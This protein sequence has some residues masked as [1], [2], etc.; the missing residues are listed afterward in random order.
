MVVN[1]RNFN[2]RITTNG[3][4]ASIALLGVLGCGSNQN[5]SSPA[6]AKSSSKQLT[7]NV[8]Y[9]DV[10]MNNAIHKARSTVPVFISALKNPR[11]GMMQFQIKMRLIDP[12]QANDEHIWLS[13]VTYDGSQFHGTIDSG[14][15]PQL[16]IGYK[17]GDVLSVKA[18]EIS[19]WCFIENGRL[20]GDFTD[21]LLYSRANPSGK[22]RIQE[23]TG[24]TD[25]DF[26]GPWK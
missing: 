12:N 23:E 11:P 6:S 8:D 26:T 10:G 2:F 4:L 25:A 19:D 1:I 24:Y 14:D 18:S 17:V 5:I 3:V 9:Y 13:D 15:E 16:L 20:R 7:T 22:K 21:K